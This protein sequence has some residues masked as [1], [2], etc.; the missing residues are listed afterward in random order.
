MKLSNKCEFYDKLEGFCCQLPS[1]AR[2]AD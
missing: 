1:E 2:L